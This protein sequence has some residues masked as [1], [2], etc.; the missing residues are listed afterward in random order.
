[1]GKYLEL[2]LIKNNIRHIEIN[3]HFPRYSRMIFLAGALIF[4]ILTANYIVIYVRFT[5][6]QKELAATETV[7]RSKR[8]LFGFD[9]LEKEWRAHCAKLRTVNKM[10]GA[11]S[12]WG[13]RLKGFSNLLPPGM[14]ITRIEAS[15]S[16]DK[17][18]FDIE[19]IALP[20]EKK[21]LGDVEAFISALEFNSLFGKGIKIESHERKTINSRDVEVFRISF[22]V[23]NTN[24]T[25][26]NNPVNN[27][28]TAKT[29]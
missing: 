29:K 26:N 21:G 28:D 15:N 20:N 27:P 24:N 19:I 12:S 5:R 13:S 3:R 11:R 10:I 8:V 14:C 18:K 9:D 23:S 16:E 25:A 17:M 2:N 4:F 7:L 1:M 6:A 22:S